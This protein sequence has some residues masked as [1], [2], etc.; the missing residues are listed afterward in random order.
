MIDIGVLGYA[1]RTFDIPV[2]PMIVGLMLGPVME[3][4][5]SRALAISQGNPSVLFTRPASVVILWLA[6]V[7]VVTPHLPKLIRVL[8]AARRSPARWRALSAKRRDA[9]RSADTNTVPPPLQACW[10]HGGLHDH[11]AEGRARDL[12]R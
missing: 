7:A 1:M 3:A 6:F 2:A 11:A 12:G 10:G 4:Q 5:L 9:R 8:R